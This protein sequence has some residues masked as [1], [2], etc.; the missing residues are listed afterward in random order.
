[1]ERSYLVQRLRLPHASKEHGALLE[2]FSFG[3]GL[4]N[5][6]LS[7]DAMEI[8]RKI[9]SFDY[10]GSAE[11]EF[12]AVPKALQ[13]IAENA[14]KYITFS[15][16]ISNKQIYIITQKEWKEETEKTIRAFAKNDRDY[17][18]KECVNLD[19]SINGHYPFG[20]KE[21]I[22]EHQLTQGWLELDNGYFFFI[23]KDMFETTAKL[24]GIKFD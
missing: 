12:G 9:F 11:F 18:T 6:G 23:N 14:K 1:M 24:F 8:L 4:K 16:E 7:N 13:K 21:K 3:G 17:R 19:V 15:I 5:G 2:A 20:N 22:P 10:M